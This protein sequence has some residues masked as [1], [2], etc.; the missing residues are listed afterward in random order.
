MDE[1]II[2]GA[3][4][5]YTSLSF[6]HFDMEER[7]DG[8]AISLDSGATWERFTGRNERGQSS[9]KSQNRA[10]FLD[11][12]NGN[13][14]DAATWVGCAR[15]GHTIQVRI[16][17]DSS[18]EYTGFVLDY[19][20]VPLCGS[21]TDTNSC[22]LAPVTQCDLSMDPPERTESNTQAANARSQRI[23]GGS[24]VT[25]DNVAP[26]YSAFIP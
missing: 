7:W 26:F 25:N 8:V 10:P 9:D 6:S 24:V 16:W 18:N 11:Q 14:H 1:T 17:T 22:H 21:Y 15:P 12:I 19:D 13:D 2:I 20:R 5:V 23:V 3:S 4:D